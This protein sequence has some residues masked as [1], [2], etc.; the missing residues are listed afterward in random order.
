LYLHDLCYLSIAVFTQTISEPS[1]VA[2]HSPFK[3]KSSI[4]PSWGTCALAAGA[5]GAGLA[6]A[7]P[8]AATRA[9]ESLMDRPKFR[10]WIQGRAR[11]RMF[12][13]LEATGYRCP[14][15][16]KILAQPK[17]AVAF[18]KYYLRDYHAYTD[19]NLSW[20]A[21][22]EAQAMSISAAMVGYPEQGQ[23]ADWHLNKLGCALI[24]ESLQSR[25]EPTSLS[26]SIY[27]YF[28]TPFTP[29]HSPKQNKN[30]KQMKLMILIDFDI[31]E[32]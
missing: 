26:L 21:A 2:Q 7:A 5:C 16:D 29:S 23:L 6:V 4:M 32:W 9:A 10:G 30:A 24:P 15:V 8:T 13:R 19:G 11:A 28:I 25:S 20:E 1:R 31:Y 14:I 27:N 17:T 3:S 18:P 22:T 12:K